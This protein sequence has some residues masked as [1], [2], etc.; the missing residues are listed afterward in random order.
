MLPVLAVLL[1]ACCA[2]YGWCVQRQVNIAAPLIIQILGK[3]RLVEMN[4]LHGLTCRA[5]VCKLGLR[6][7]Q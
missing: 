6:L 3:F 7:F 5:V 2:G 4:L 1:I